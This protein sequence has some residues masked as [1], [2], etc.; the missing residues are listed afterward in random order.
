MTCIK[1]NNRG[2]TLAEMALVIFM[3]GVLSLGVAGFMNPLIQHMAYKNFSDGTASEGR[4][5]LKRMK[6]EISQVANPAS[7]TTATATAFAFT[8]AAGSDI[9]YALDGTNLE[10]NNVAIARNISNLTFSYWDLS[11]SALANPQ[12]NPNETDILRMQVALTVSQGGESVT[13]QTQVRPR[14]LLT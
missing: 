11:D 12:T 4:L 1:N 13:Y 5:A 2:F 6:R 10:R 7:V 3:L 14:N 8:D 9:S